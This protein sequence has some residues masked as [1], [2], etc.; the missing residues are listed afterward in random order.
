MRN[1]ILEATAGVLLRDGVESFTISRVAREAGLSV[2][3]LRYHF[4]SKR[5]LLEALIDH[6]VSGFDAALN[7]AGDEPGAKTRAYITAT[8]SGK[9]SRQLAAAL[10]ATVA[11]DSTLLAVLRRHFVHWQSLLDEDGIDTTAGLLIRLAMD[12]WWLAAF[13]DL[14]PPDDQ[15]AARLRA[16]IEAL[17]TEAIDG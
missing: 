13:A 7:S 6:A 12:G 3:G 9:E 11:V 2:G 5:E 8:L 17:V 14:A 10:V 15:A 16:R 1:G 4:A